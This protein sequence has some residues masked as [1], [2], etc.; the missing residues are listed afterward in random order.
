M[1]GNKEKT[2]TNQMADQLYT[3]NQKEHT[4][5]MGSVNK[6]LEGAQGRAGDMYGSMY[7]GYKNFIDGKG[8]FDPAKYGGGGDY[9]GVGAAAADGRFGEVE[10]S[11]RNFMNSGGVDTGMFNRFQGALADVAGNGGWDEGRIKSMDENIR[12]FKDIAKTGGVDAEGQ[13]R[14]RGG[15]VFDEF[16][17]TG[18]YSDKDIANIRSRATSVIPAYYDVAKNEAARRSAVQGGYGPGNSALMAKM[19]R[20][21]SR[22]AAGAA[23]DAEVGI[24]DKVNTGRQWGAGG[25]AESEGALQNL[26]SQNRLGA[27]TGASNTEAGM[28]NSIAGNRIG[29]ASAGGSNEIGMQGTI[30][31]GKMFG[32]TGLEGMAESAA[33]RAAAGAAGSA[34]DARWRADFDREGQQFGLE[35]MRSLYGMAPGEVDM[36]LGHNQSGRGLNNQNQQGIIN[37]RYAGNQRKGVDWGKIAQ[38]GGTVALAAM[39]DQ[40]KK[41]AESDVDAK[42][43]TS[44]VSTKNIISRFKK[45]RISTWEYKDDPKATRHVG[46]M[47]QDMQRIFG[48][49]DGKTIA[50]VDVMGLL[51]L[52]GKA[53]AERAEA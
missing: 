14:M 32:T 25:M 12:G 9:G 5:F 18:G 15:G 39:S 42:T 27:L 2:K 23:L 21:Q 43:N 20:D 17:K 10:G 49:G 33:A 47:A 6:G 48:V 26:M 22:G 8:N 50:L 38:V 1:G 3:Q 52:L 53:F 34:A 13:N 28:V 7:G 24:K 30:Q 29:A 4:D 31:K 35:G 19:A 45:L 44:G 51:M 36:Y 37:S 11:Y 46:P 40:N 16:A 41:K